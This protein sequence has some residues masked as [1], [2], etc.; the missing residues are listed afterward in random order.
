MC[1]RAVVDRLSGGRWG[2]PVTGLGNMNRKY[3]RRWQLAFVGMHV[4]GM[5]FF[6]AC[7]WHQDVSWAWQ[8]GSFAFA[9]GTGFWAAV[10]VEIAT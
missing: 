10:L 7:F 5:A 2:G 8:V 6:A 3:K 1:A 9:Y 4:L